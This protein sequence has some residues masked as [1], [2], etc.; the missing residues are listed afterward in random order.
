MDTGSVLLG[1]A[2]LAVVVFIAVRP[3]L[4]QTGR[5]E[6]PATIAEQLIDSRERVLVQ[7]RDLDFD[8]ATGKINAGDYAALR[9]KLVVEGV[10]ILKQLDALGVTADE[11]EAN[12]A[13]PDDQIEIA[14][15]QKR[16]LRAP[17][18][19]GVAALSA[20]PGDEI[21]AAV[22]QARALRMAPKPAG[23]ALKPATSAPKPTGAPA[24]LKA[25][26]RD[27]NAEIEANV[28]LR[29]SKAP[30]A[31]LTGAAEM[32]MVTE[33][34]AGNEKPSVAEALADPETLAEDHTL[35]CA[36][37]GTAVLPSDR[38]CPKCGSPQTVACRNC[39]RVARADDQF[40]AQ[41]GQA[42]PAS[43]AGTAKA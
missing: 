26:G 40:C 35:S 10:A 18:T 14:V 37:C 6:Q 30:G 23:S 31:A 27:L 25:A 29:R 38:F 7:L 9:A 21:E 42:L 32:R 3:L 34:P 22:A 41:C 33:P 28:A 17:A 24:G 1:L 20:A 5:R 19:I 13:M 12:S 4:E 15:A 36:Q 8:D 16:A 11:G 43:V 39:G 2:L